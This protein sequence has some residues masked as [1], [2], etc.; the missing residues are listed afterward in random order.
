MNSDHR[1]SVGIVFIAGNIV[2]NVLLLVY[3]VSNF[4]TD[5]QL[6][7]PLWSITLLEFLIPIGSAFF[8]YRIYHARLEPQESHVFDQLVFITGSVLFLLGTGTALYYFNICPVFVDGVGAA[9]GNVAACGIPGE[10]SIY[11]GLLG[12]FVI[13][14]KK[15]FEGR[16]GLM[17]TGLI[18]VF[19]TVIGTLVLLIRL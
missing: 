1:I 2:L 19:S 15:M 5:A 10:L 14:V 7:L 16:A 18:G 13:I 11:I 17:V 6:L 12:S 9:V 8:F 4:G 3:S